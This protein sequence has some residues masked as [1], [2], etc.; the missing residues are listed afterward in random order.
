MP[1]CGSNHIKCY[2]CEHNFLN[3]ERKFYI[4]GEYYCEECA[5]DEYGM[6]HGH[7]DDE[8]NELEEIFKKY[9]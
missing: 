8:Q 2:I 5:F 3:E 6:I 9:L 4:D 7:E 1:K